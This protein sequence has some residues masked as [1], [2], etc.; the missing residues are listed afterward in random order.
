MKT[1][2]ERTMTVVDKKVVKAGPVTAEALFKVATEVAKTMEVEREKKMRETFNRRVEEC[3]NDILGCCK[4]DAACGKFRT[5]CLVDMVRYNADMAAEVAARLR[6]NPFCFKT[7][8]VHDD[9]VI[10][11]VIKWDK[12]AE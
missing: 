7:D 1:Y 8:I 9:G 11:L 6:E 12:G 10:T 2:Y 3:M 5:D 4:R